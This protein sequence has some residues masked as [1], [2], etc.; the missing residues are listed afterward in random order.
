[1]KMYAL[2]VALLASV[3]FVGCTSDDEATE[4]GALKQLSFSAVADA[5]SRPSYVSER[6]KTQLHP[7]EGNS[8]TF[9]KNDAISVFDGAT[10][11]NK[12]FATNEDGASVT[13]TGAAPEST[14]YTALYPYQDGAS[15]SEGVISAELP[16]T[17][18]AQAGTTFDPLAVLS[19]ATTTSE[20]MEFAFKNVC[21]LVKFTTTEALAKVVFKGKN[22]EKVA[23]NV[24]ITVG[25]APSYSGADAESITLLP[26]SPAKTI[27]AGTYYI[28]VLPQA[29]ANGFTLEAYK[30]SSSDKADYALEIST[31]VEVERSQILNVG[32]MDLYA[33]VNANG[34]EFVDLGIEITEGGK[35]YK[36]LFA[37]M[38]VGASAPEKF[39]DYFAWGET[40]PYYEAGWTTDG[41]SGDEVTFGGTWKSSLKDSSVGYDWVNYAWCAGTNKTLTKYCGKSSYGNNGYT[42]TLTQ[43]E[44]ADDAAH[45]N[46]GGDWVMPTTA[47][48]QALY[49]NCSR[50]WTTLNDVNGWKF[51]STKDTSKSIFLPAAGYFGATSV[52]GVG[53]RGYCW[54]SSLYTDSPA[55]AYRL[56]FSSD[57]VYPAYSDGRDYGQSVRPVLRMASGE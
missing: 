25:D 34:H 11:Q 40:T 32:E 49:D 5:G 19:V 36:L 48:W 21:G 52:D 38:N 29:F 50:E 16:T 46:W 17:Q 33:S 51:T 26:L 53:S 31:N 14:T 3:S 43:L 37:T 45:V 42:D 8:V 23:G 27:A 47:E 15:I 13:F 6:M 9:C 22:N 28:S 24:S 20:E 35:T 39:G 1:T 18:Y 55:R 44:L 4:G 10:S 57:D 30:T 7:N 41:K 12:R 54:S 56:Y 2:L